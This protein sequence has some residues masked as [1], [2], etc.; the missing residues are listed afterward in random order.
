MLDG[1]V[2]LPKRW[3]SVTEKAVLKDS[4]RN[5]R[6]KLTCMTKKQHCA[7]FWGKASYI[8]FYLFSLIFIKWDCATFAKLD[9]GFLSVKN[10]EDHCFSTKNLSVDYSLQP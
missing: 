8:F 2:K 10:I 7:I 5:L 3:D 9:V 1:I 6:K 4:V